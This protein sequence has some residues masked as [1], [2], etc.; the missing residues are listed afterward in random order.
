MR[1]AGATRPSHSLIPYPS[2]FRRLQVDSEL[3][4]SGLEDQ[5]TEAAATKV[6]HAIEPVS[7]ATLC[8]GVWWRLQPCV[9]EA[10]AL[11]G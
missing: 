11:C 5:A 3:S 8:G 1:C 7:A 6:C 9:V 2:V 4:D 10:A